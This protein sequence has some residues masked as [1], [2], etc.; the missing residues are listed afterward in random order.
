[1]AVSL[2]L[3]RRCPKCNQPSIGSYLTREDHADLHVYI[4]DVTEENV[5]AVRYQPSGRGTV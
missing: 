3:Q 4:P 5:T 2:V 1:M